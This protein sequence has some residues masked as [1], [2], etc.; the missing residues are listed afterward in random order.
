MDKG[1]YT[2]RVGEN[3]DG[4]TFDSLEDWYSCPYKYE[5]MNDAM[6]F[7]NY[8]RTLKEVDGYFNRMIANI[9]IDIGR[10]GETNITP[11]LES[12]KLTSSIEGYIRDFDSTINNIN[13]YGGAAPKSLINTDLG[14]RILRDLNNTYYSENVFCHNALYYKS[15]VLRDNKLIG[16]RNWQYAGFYPPE[17][18]DVVHKYLEYI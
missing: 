2:I 7:K 15:F 18:E 3:I 5:I 1:R 6:K 9:P 11:I 16:I 10:I 13:K 8:L 4:D 14:N 12:T 17:F